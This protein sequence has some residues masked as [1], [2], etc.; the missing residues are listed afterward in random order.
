M[1][2][3]ASKGTYGFPR[4]L[5]LTIPPFKLDVKGGGAGSGNP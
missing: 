2:G 5:R 1:V 3:T 4:S